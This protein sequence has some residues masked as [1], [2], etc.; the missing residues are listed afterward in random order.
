[1]LPID[2]VYQSDAAGDRSPMIA[3]AATN[4]GNVKIFTFEVGP[5]KSQAARIKVSAH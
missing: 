3:M 5:G 4:F 1:L 2:A